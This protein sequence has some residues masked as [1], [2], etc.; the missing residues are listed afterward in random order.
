MSGDQNAGRSIN[1]KI[2]NSYFDGGESKYLGTTCKYRNSME[3]EIKSRLKSEFVCYQSVQNLLPS[4]FTYLLTYLLP[5]C[6]TALPEK[7]IGF[8]LVKQFPAFCRTRR[9]ITAL[10]RSRHLSLSWSRSIQSMPP[11]HFLKIHLNIILPSIPGSSKWPLSRRFRHQKPVYTSPLPRTCYMP[12]LS[13]S[14]QFDHQNI[15]IITFICNC[16]ICHALNILSL[17]LGD[18]GSTVVKVLYYKSEGRCFDPSWCQWL[19]YWYKILLIALWPWSRLS[20]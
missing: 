8:Q 12:H 15:H 19:F 18:C 13:H 6:S 20:L 14:S 1:M 10:T 16:F 11:S 9:F 4:S 5:P 7:L 2:D 17:L 3:D